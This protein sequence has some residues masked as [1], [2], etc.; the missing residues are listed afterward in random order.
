MRLLFGYVDPTSFDLAHPGPNVAVRE[1]ALDS[2][3]AAVCAYLS[4]IDPDCVVL[5][6][7]SESTPTVQRWV[8]GMLERNSLRRGIHVLCLSRE[9]TARARVLSG[10]KD[11]YQHVVLG[12]PATESAERLALRYAEA[13]ALDQARVWVSCLPQRGGQRVTLV[14]CGVVN[15][16]TAVRLLHAGYEV[17]LL[18]SGPPPGSASSV[19]RCTWSGGDGRIFSWNE[20]RHH[21]RGHTPH[22]AAQVFQRVVSEGGWLCRRPETLTAADRRWIEL[23]DATA[24]W[25]RDVYN[26]DII[27]TNRDSADG[28]RRLRDAAPRLFSDV[29]FQS[30]LVRVYP[31]AERFHKAERDERRIGAIKRRIEQLAD[32]LPALTQAVAQGSVFAALEV[33]GFGLNIHRFARALLD[34]LQASG[35]TIHWNTPVGRVAFDPLGNVE[36]VASGSRFFEAD[37]YVVSPGVAGGQC[38]EGSLGRS[39]IAAMIGVWISIPRPA[40]LT[41]PPMKVARDGFAS[42]ES[43]AGA[44]VIPGTAPDGT[45]VLHLSAGHGFLGH[46][47]A[48]VDPYE[49]SAM[50]RA[51]EETAASLFPDWFRAARSSGMLEASRSSCIRPWT[52]TC[53]GLFETQPT[54]TGGVFALAGGHNTGGFAQSPQVAEAVLAALD[55]RTHPMHRLYHPRRLGSFLD[56]PR[57]RAQELDRAS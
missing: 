37:H 32:E 47:A 44:N 56:S 57:P 14:G 39:Q 29:G 52:P 8:R 54:A 55:G 1:L 15:L 24:P 20:A 38:L 21:M 30:Q 13:V 5:R 46:D 4:R 33:Q 42:D 2:F 31:D 49:L 28:W 22:A 51:V 26:D 41:I 45:P 9:P 10:P 36:G 11:A 3:D 19:P 7:S 25:L 16:I 23:Y 40:D 34:Y 17:T 35:A 43:A 53:L 12:V 50:F 6:C 48:S 27:A 18:D